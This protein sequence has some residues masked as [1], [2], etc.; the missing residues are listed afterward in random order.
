MMTR[1]V[2][3]CVTAVL[4][5]QRVHGVMCTTTQTNRESY[6]TAAFGVGER[7]VLQP[8]QLPSVWRLGVANVADHLKP[9]PN[10]FPA[11]IELAFAPSHEPSGERVRS[12]PAWPAL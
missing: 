5:L 8:L 10:R 6:A 11:L 9:I 3:E 4:M 12:C 7:V 1:F 2:G